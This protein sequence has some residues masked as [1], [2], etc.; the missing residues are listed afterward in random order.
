MDKIQRICTLEVLTK[1]ILEN[2]EKFTCGDNDMDEFFYKE[3]FT[4]TCTEKP[5]KILLLRR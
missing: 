5:Q 2:C 4:S 3:H 1:E